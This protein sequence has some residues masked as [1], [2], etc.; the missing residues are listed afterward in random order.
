MTRRSRAAPARMTVAV[1]LAVALGVGWC[2]HSRLAGGPLVDEPITGAELLWHPGINS[3]GPDAA[4]STTAEAAT[5]LARLVDHAPRQPRGEVNCPAD[6]G[7][8][9]VV[10]FHTAHGHEQRVRVALTGCAGPIGQVMSEPLRAQLGRL[11]PAG[12]WPERLE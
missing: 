6:F 12:F 4:S 1:A 10:T 5:T 11:A 2:L 7:S 9:V 3:A 8:N